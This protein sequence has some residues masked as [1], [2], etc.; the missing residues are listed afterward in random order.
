MVVAL[1]G[2]IVF[3]A[4]NGSDNP[5]PNCSGVLVGATAAALTL[6]LLGAALWLR[7][8][9]SEELTKAR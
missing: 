3:L 7:K 2:F 8:A 1:F 4:M 9:K 6:S 5:E